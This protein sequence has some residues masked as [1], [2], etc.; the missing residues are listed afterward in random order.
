VEN[1]AIIGAK[2]K[3]KTPLLIHRLTFKGPS[4]ELPF[5][6]PMPPSMAILSLLPIL[7]LNINFD[8]SNAFN[9][10]GESISKESVDWSK[11][12]FY[13]DP[14]GNQRMVIQLLGQLDVTKLH[15]RQHVKWQKRQRRP[16]SYLVQPS[17]R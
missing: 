9:E 6:P 13:F 12:G 8:G 15:W 11:P 10:L 16:M 2:Y 1:E 17:S 5:V 3:S 4:S 7:E 14:N